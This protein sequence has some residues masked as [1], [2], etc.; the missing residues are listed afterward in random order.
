MHASRWARHV[1]A[2]ATGSGRGAASSCR[3]PPGTAT[4]TPTRRGDNDV[5]VVGQLGK[6]RLHGVSTHQHGR[7][8]VC[9]LDEL[10]HHLEGRRLWGGEGG[11]LRCGLA[12]LGAGASTAGAR[13]GRADAAA[14]CRRMHSSASPAPRV[15]AAL[16]ARRLAAGGH[17]ARRTLCVCRASSR[18]G[19]RMTARAPALGECALSLAS[20]G[21][22]GAGWAAVSAGASAADCA[23]LR[24]PRPGVL[25]PPAL[26]PALAAAAGRR[27]S[28]G[29]AAAPGRGRS[30]RQR[31]A[32]GG[33]SS[34]WGLHHGDELRQARAARAAAAR[35][36]AAGWQLTSRPWA[37]RRPPSCRSR[38]A[39]CQ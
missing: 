24:L 29:A 4:S 30:A 10:A 9:E 28:R 2:A 11:A 23:D 19:D 37:A 12:G 1:L 7:A 36:A 27:C 8:Q 18:V 31:G 35:A 21:R 14:G 25:Q 22:G 17:A 33:R 34:A 26:H 5:R 38:C 32:P 3:G 6:L 13:E 39:P 16:R 20:R 15:L